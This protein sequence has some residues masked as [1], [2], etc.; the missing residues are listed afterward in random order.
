MNSLF[1]WL[2]IVLCLLW[3][4]VGCAA[5]L[6]LS[7]GVDLLRKLNLPQERGRQPAQQ[8]AVEQPVTII[9][10]AGDLVT[11][12]AELSGLAWYGD[13]LIFLP[14]FPRRLDN[15]L[16]F[17]P[18][19]EILRFLHQGSAGPLVPQPLPLI[20]GESATLL[21]GFDGF[22]AI[23]FQGDQAFLTVEAYPNKTMLSYLL[24][25]QMAP[26]L[27]GLTLDLQTFQ[28]IQPQT[29]LI[30]S[31]DE[32]IL[33]ADDQVLTFYE[34]NGFILNDQPMA[35]RFTQA[36]L[37]PLG[38]LPFP[39]IEYRITDA[40]PLDA[41]N[42]FWAI[43]YFFTGDKHIRD[44]DLGPDPLAVQYGIGVTHQ[45]SKA[46]ERLVE[47]QYTPEGITRID[48][49]PIQLQLLDGLARNWEGIVRLEEGELSG[50]LLVTDRFPETLFAFVPRP[51]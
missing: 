1:R 22:E 42:R 20:N 36:D 44:L 37:Q 9:P 13:L 11:P 45:T 41:A 48:Q 19:Q 7:K 24:T 31:G 16:Y 23:A 30:N 5:G 34:L 49:P 33:L 29:K 51:K 2:V 32:A 25:G 21:A 46:V 4:L 3:G 18:R 8:A 15:Q 6:P 26:D 12:K 28:E 27:S 14:Q 39:T 50:F 10:L 17:L 40:T 38:T 43:N 35:H 47:F